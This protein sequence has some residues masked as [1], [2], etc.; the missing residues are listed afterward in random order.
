METRSTQYG[1]TID[2]K[3]TEWV[4][5]ILRILLALV[6]FPH[7]AQKLFGLFGGYGF[8][9]TMQYFTEI[10]GI[11]WMLGFSVILLETIGALFL[12]MGIATR[13]MAFFYTL[14]GLGIMMVS[15][16]QNGFFMNWYGNQEG[17]GVEYFLLWLGISIALVISGG[18]KYSVDKAL[19]SRIG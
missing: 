2:K 11:P 15:H 17:E 18:G 1:E 8:N 4:P 7:G 9:G 13:L 6:V 19:L 12:A 16:L 5:L 14:L 10:I 3:S